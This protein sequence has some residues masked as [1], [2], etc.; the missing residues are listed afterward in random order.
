MEPD[1]G[2][3]MPS[4]ETFSDESQ[5]HQFDIE[6]RHHT[7]GFTYQLSIPGLPN[8]RS[9]DQ[10]FPSLD[11]ARQHAREQAWHLIGQMVKSQR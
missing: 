9:G 5:G 2:V 11:K 3:D 4:V 7:N 8:V 10:L 1:Q 6:V